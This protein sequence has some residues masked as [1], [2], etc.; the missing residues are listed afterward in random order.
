MIVVYPALFYLAYYHLSDFAVDFYSDPYYLYFGLSGLYYP[1][2]DLYFDLDF[3]DLAAVSLK[4]TEPNA[5]YSVL[6]HL[7]DFAVTHSYTHLYPQHIFY[8]A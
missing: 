5:N 2:S 7:S 3:S 6:H 1:Y 4:A 8:P